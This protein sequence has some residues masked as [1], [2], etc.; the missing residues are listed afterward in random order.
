MQKSLSKAQMPPSIAQQ[1]TVIDVNSFLLSMEAL[2][3]SF[4]YS[5]WLTHY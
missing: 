1:L 5:I 2:L 4:G 3:H